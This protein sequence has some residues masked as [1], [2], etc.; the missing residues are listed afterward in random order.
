M[1]LIKPRLRFSFTGLV[2]FLF[3]AGSC[4]QAD[5]QTGTDRKA[6]FL[7][8][9]ANVY[10]LLTD[11][12]KNG[13]PGNDINFDRTGETAVMRGFQGG[14]M[15][16]VIQ[17]IREG[18][19]DSLGV[20]ALW[21]TPWFEQ[22]HGSID[23]STGITYGYHG[24]WT[25]D[26]TSI[27][28]NFGSA[29][30]LAVLVKTAHDHGIRIV[31]DVIINHTGPVT[32]KDPVWPGDWVR[33]E[34][35]CTYKDYES[36]VTCTLVENLPD[37]RTE[38]DSP[39]D[40]PPALLEKWEQEGRLEKEMEE[41]DDFF[42]RTGYPRAPRYYLIKWLTDFIRKY[43]IDG[44]R[45]DTAKHI[46]EGVW[47]ELFGEAQKA[48]R[49]WKEKNPGEVLDGNEFYMVGEVY[50]YGIGTGRTFDFGDIKVD[51]YDQSI[52]S[53]INFDF[54]YNATGDYETLFS[55]YSK[56]LN[57]TL[58]GKGVLNYLSSHDDGSPFDKKRLKPMEAGTKLLLSPGACQIYYGDESCR[59][60]I[61][62]GAN[63]D[64]NLRGPM[65][66]DEIENNSS[67]NGFVIGEVM[68]HYRKLGQFRR[69][70][71]AVGAGTHEK[72]S[73]E[74]YVF[75]RVFQKGEY[76]D[77]VLVGLGLKTGRKTLQAGGTFRDGTRLY[78]Y[79]SGSW[80]SVK[81]GRVAIDSEWEIVLLGRK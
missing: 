71:P 75:S 45:L 60:L 29:E 27:D 4:V 16:G 73:G 34:P 54:K 14:D 8:E 44:Y 9:N 53:L 58:Q 79:Y 61:I 18:Y 37:I 50:N 38:S 65:N 52:H 35:R 11:R 28:P 39:V 12:F 57:G 68:E 72:V 22:I 32:D 13:N 6:P 43:G 67:R 5:Q 2:L 17:K 59:N 63:G 80:T 42:E 10:F 46:E 7:W 74:P 36:T 31:M 40:L 69:D 21:M 26:W 30:E 55:S 77:K 49:E 64:A 33:T 15:A 56:K 47:K 3:L 19:F 25:R 20:T 41:L 81:K 66:W 23:E 62:P 51:F 24:Y 1:Y 78:D 48:F 76:Q 70:H